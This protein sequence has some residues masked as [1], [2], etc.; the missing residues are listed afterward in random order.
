[1]FNILVQRPKRLKQFLNICQPH[2]LKSPTHS[3]MGTDGILKN[4]KFHKWVNHRRC[5]VPEVLDF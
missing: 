4:Q 1:M 3:I 5:G 2:R